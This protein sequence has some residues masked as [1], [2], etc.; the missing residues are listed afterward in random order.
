M[1][2]NVLVYLIIELWKTE[3]SNSTGIRQGSTMQVPLKQPSYRIYEAD[4]DMS[5]A[6]SPPMN[7]GMKMNPQYTHEG[8][9]YRK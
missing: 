4:N 6:L 7:F 9:I 2:N 1:K 8:F 3:K 5:V